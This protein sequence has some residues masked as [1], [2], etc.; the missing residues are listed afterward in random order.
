MHPVLSY[1][2][3][4]RAIYV[5]PSSTV[6]VH[7]VTAEWDTLRLRESQRSSR[8]SECDGVVVRTPSAYVPEPR[9]CA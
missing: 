9:G 8:M 4:L 1:P 6:L 3:L 2:P 5:A 7:H